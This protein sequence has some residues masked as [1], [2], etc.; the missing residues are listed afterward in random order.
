L[1]GDAQHA[2][3]TTQRIDEP[4]VCSALFVQGNGLVGALHCAFEVTGERE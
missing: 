3:A 2:T 1:T 4:D